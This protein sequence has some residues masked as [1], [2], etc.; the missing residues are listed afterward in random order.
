MGSDPRLRRPLQSA[1][2]GAQMPTGPHSG[3]WSAAH[4][5]GGAPHD[6]EDDLRPPVVRGRRGSHDRPDRRHVV[7]LGAAS[8]DADH[9]LLGKR[10]GELL[11]AC[12]LLRT[13]TRDSPKTTPPGQ[14]LRS[15]LRID[16]TPLLNGHQPSMAW[17][18]HQ[19]GCQYQAPD[20]TPSGDRRRGAGGR[21]EDAVPPI[22]RP[23]L[24]RGPAIHGSSEW[25]VAF[26][27]QPSCSVRDAQ[28][29]PAVPAWHHAACDQ[30]ASES[31]TG[32]EAG[33]LRISGHR[34]RHRP[35]RC[36][37]PDA[38]AVGLVPRNGSGCWHVGG[39]KG[40]ARP[41]NFRR[42]ASARNTLRGTPLTAVPGAADGW[43]TVDG[44]S[45]R[46]LTRPGSGR[47]FTAFP[48]IAPASER[49]GR[50]GDAASP[51]SCLVCGHGRVTPPARGGP[52]VG[53]R[54]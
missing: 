47:V 3:G 39:R 40:C 36:R 12:D 31:C 35:S 49:P 23:G 20:N 11:L 22:A 54:R 26:R 42:P 45:P 41:A 53:E 52:E 25:Q 33:R 51:P 5:D 10:R 2:P 44:G 14:P 46:V 21:A 8:E 6:S 43:T 13:P 18:L 16:Q 1:W 17:S 29:A 4:P 9:Q 34:G 48:V 37:R 30:P 19:S 28:T 7:V 24:R 50:R 15:C 32:T 38:G 27:G